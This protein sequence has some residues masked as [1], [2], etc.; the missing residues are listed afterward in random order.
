[1][2]RVEDLDVDTL[3]DENTKLILTDDAIKE[4]PNNMTMHVAPPVGQISYLCK[5]R[6]LV[7]KFLSNANGATWCPNCFLMQVVPPGGQIS[8]AS[9]ALPTNSCTAN[10]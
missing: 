10:Y 4:I 2:T 8:N 6:H 1:M 9:G 5:W 3:I 7:A